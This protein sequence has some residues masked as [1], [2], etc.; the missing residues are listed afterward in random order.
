MLD[1]MT[2]ESSGLVDRESPYSVDEAVARLTEVLRAKGVT[3]FAVVDHSGEAA[4]AGLSLRP[5]KLLIFGNPR[6]GTAL[7]EAA[8]RSAIDLPLK[9]LVWQDAGGTTWITS[10]HPDFVRARH[11]LGP[12]SAGVL[13]AADAFAAAAT[14]K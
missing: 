4:R 12:E 3:L 5:T 14:A 6:A 7:M 10:N 9:L 13:A 8:P 11:G 1:A 2:T